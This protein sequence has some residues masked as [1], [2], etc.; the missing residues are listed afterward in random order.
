MIQ[1]HYF[2]N[3]FFRQGSFLDKTINLKRRYFHDWWKKNFKN[4]FEHIKRNPISPF[5][6]DVFYYGVIY[7]HDCCTINVWLFT[8]PPLCNCYRYLMKFKI[9]SD[10]R[11]SLEPLRTRFHF[12]FIP[13]I[14]VMAF[15]GKPGMSPTHRSFVMFTG[16]LTYHHRSQF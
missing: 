14:G 9:A 3:L 1:R 4:S 2:Q 13:Y 10:M 16:F 6:N 7:I 11:V 12:H 15:E 8:V 5:S